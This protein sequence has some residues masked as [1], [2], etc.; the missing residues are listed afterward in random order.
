MPITNH[1][2][3]SNIIIIDT[4]YKDKIA[5]NQILLFFEIRTRV[6]GFSRISDFHLLLSGK[7]KTKSYILYKYNKLHLFY[8]KGLV[9]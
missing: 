8:E 2:L 5:H 1:H 9:I 3:I 7:K 4:R 6:H